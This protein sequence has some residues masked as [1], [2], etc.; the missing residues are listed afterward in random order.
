VYPRSRAECLF[1]DRQLRGWAL[2]V[3]LLGGEAE[4][5]VGTEPALEETRA[6]LWRIAVW[7]MGR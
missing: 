3:V 4:A 5:R 6:Q 2:V 1:N 7:Y